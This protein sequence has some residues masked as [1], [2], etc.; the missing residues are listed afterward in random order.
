MKHSSDDLETGRYKIASCETHTPE[1]FGQ[2]SINHAVE[3]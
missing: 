3:G 1:T 2:H